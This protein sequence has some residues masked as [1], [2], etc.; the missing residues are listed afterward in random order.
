VR[1]EEGEGG[2]LKIRSIAKE[3]EP[4]CCGEEESE[5]KGRGRGDSS[6]CISLAFSLRKKR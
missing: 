3:N 4:R 2:K 6:M 5:E 1:R